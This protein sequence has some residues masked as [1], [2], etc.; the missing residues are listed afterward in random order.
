VAERPSNEHIERMI[1][2]V[3]GKEPRYERLESCARCGRCCAGIE[4]EHLE[5]DG[6]GLAV[7]AIYD[8][9]DRPAFCDEWPIG[10]PVMFD[11]CGFRWR[12]RVDGTDLDPDEA[13]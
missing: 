3:S 7:C 4:C 9:P 12:D 11:T 5:Y 8:S 10:P 13:R 1:R 2:I 6:E